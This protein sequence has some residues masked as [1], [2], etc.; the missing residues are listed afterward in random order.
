MFLPAQ[1]LLQGRADVGTGPADVR[2]GR[3][4]RQRWGETGG[5]VFGESHRA[6]LGGTG[7][8]MQL[9]SVEE[10]LPKH[11]RGDETSRR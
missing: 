6:G 9:A 2:M 8:N 11:E 10:H 1:P 4:R 5:R 3:E 7:Q